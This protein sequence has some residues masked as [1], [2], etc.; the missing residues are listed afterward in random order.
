MTKVLSVYIRE[1]VM[2][3]LFLFKLGFV[4]NQK[5]TPRTLVIDEEKLQEI[6]CYSQSVIVKLQIY[7]YISLAYAAGRQNLSLVRYMYWRKSELR[8]KR[9]TGLS[10]FWT[11]PMILKYLKKPKFWEMT[12]GMRSGGKSVRNIIIPD[13]PQPRMKTTENINVLRRIRK[14]MSFVAPWKK[15][16]FRTN[17]TVG[18][19]DWHTMKCYLS[20]LTSTEPTYH[21]KYFCHSCNKKW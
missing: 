12:S 18:T 10:E 5:Y 7:S 13:G 20:L 19:R 1:H 9:S 15:H 11:N 14:R 21:F 6:S 3:H 17:T 16:I 8:R 2:M 4:H